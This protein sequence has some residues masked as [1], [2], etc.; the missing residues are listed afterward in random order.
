MV[1]SIIAGV[2]YAL[3]LAIPPAQVE[4]LAASSV[5]FVLLP[6]VLVL[7]KKTCKCEAPG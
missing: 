7:P 5:S 4:L 1:V 2:Q 6:C 3:R